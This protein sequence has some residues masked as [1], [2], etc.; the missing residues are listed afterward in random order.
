VTLLN[1]IQ[2]T[3]QAGFD[4]ADSRILSPANPPLDPSAPSRRFLLAVALVGA[5]CVSSG[6]VFGMEYLHEGFGS[7]DELTKSLGVP[8]LAVVPRTSSRQLRSPAGFDR[9]I[10]NYGSAY[11]ESMN[12]L[13][14]GLCF[15]KRS[16]GDP[17]VL[18]V[19]SSAPARARAPW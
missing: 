19:T 16:S 2:E 6:V 15:A 17:M 10:A 7:E 18:V 11:T 12:A 5:F 13:H 3:E 9:L 4:E 1:R 14:T 8:T